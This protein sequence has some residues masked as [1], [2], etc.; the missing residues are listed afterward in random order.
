MCAEQVG[1]LVD[2]MPTLLG[3]CGMPPAQGVQG[4]D[5]S[6]VVRGDA[7]RLARDGAFIESD[8]GLIGLRTPRYLCGMKTSADFRAIEDDADCFYDLREDPYEFHNLAASNPPESRPLRQALA[9]WHRET[10]WMA[11]R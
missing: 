1:S 2:V 6:P 8:R 10:P 9:A 4:Q 7:P 3:L 5:L 11:S